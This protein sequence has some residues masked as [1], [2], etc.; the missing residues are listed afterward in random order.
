AGRVAEGGRRSGPRESERRRRR[1]TGAGA[2]ELAANAVSARLRL[3][4]F[5]RLY[6][7]AGIVLLLLILYVSLAARVTQSSY[8]SSRLKAQQADLLAH[9]EQLQ[10]AEANLQAPGQVEHDAAR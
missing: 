8:E 7:A 6:L 3:D 4:A 5:G 10:Y 9:T 2:V 1:R